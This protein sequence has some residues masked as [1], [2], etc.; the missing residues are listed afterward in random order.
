MIYEKINLISEILDATLNLKCIYIEYLSNNLDDLKKLI[1]PIFTINDNE[2][3]RFLNSILGTKENHV[4]W[5][6]DFMFGNYVI[7]CL[8]EN[9]KNYLFIG[10]YLLTNNQEHLLKDFKEYN[11]SDS[12]LDLI[13]KYYISM[14]F[15]CR[16]KITSIIS[17]IKNSLYGEEINFKYI[18]KS[19]IKKSNFIGYTSDRLSF[20]SLNH[21]FIEEISILEHKLL[22]FVQCGSKVKSLKVLDKILDLYFIDENIYNLRNCKNKLIYYNTLL[23]KVVKNKGASNIYVENLF[24]IYLDKIELANSVNDTKNIFYNMVVDYCFAISEF[25]IKH[26]SSLIGD[27]IDYINLNIQNNLSVNEI[28]NLFYVS[29]TYLSRTFKK[30]TGISVIEYINKLRIKYSTLLLI[31]TCLPIQDIG[32]IIGINDINYFSRVFKKYMNETPTQYRKNFK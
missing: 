30:E 25:S 22:S 32:R 15:I 27:V 16:S 2:Y 13:K 4:Y 9:T 11:I 14:P 5:I 8:D 10:P 1:P 28:A 24:K 20:E 31:D 12:E 29:P 7:I 17:V 3:N 6:E 23:S 18:F 26:F 21:K 19:N